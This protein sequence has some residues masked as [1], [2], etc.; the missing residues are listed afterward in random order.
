M[1]KK[2][3]IN[4]SPSEHMHLVLYM[5]DSCEKRVKGLTAVSALSYLQAHCTNDPN[6]CLEQVVWLLVLSGQLCSQVYQC[7][8][9][10]LLSEAG[11]P[12]V[13]RSPERLSNVYSNGLW[14]A[15]SL[16]SLRAWYHLDVYLVL[17]LEST[18]VNYINESQQSLSIISVFM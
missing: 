9:S 2:F 16:M 1:L 14:K 5:I 12:K 17:S 13:L 4:R 10:P 11:K 3:L 8:C 18:Q 7:Y 15:I 6:M